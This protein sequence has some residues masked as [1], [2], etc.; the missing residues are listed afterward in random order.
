[1]GPRIRVP[2]GP[3][4]AREG[5]AGDGARRLAGARVAA[6]EG[7]EGLADAVPESVVE[8]DGAGA[9]VRV[10]RPASGYQ[11]GPPSG[12]HASLL[13]T[14]V[15]SDWQKQVLQ[16]SLAGNACPVPYSNPS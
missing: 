10:A 8:A 6:V 12:V 9:G 13:Q 1:M 14:T 3:G 16:P 11:G 2:G 7:R 5:G 15:P 4:V